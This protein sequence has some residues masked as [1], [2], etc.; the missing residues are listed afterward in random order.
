MNIVDILIIV[1]LVFGALVG[2]RRGFTKQLVSSIGLIVIVILA[3]VLKN[4]LSALLYENLP[5]FKFGGIFKGVT[6]LN[7][8]V[9]EVLAFFIVL[10]ILMFIF[11]ILLFVTSIFEKFL[12]MT[13]I[14]GIPSKILGAILGVLENFILVFILLYIL[15]LPIFNINGLN[16]SKLKSGILKKTPILSTQVDKSVKVI[17]EFIELKDKYESINDSNSF[18]LE[19]LDLLLKHKITTVKSVE[20]LIEKDKI[21]INNI[22]TVLQKY[23]EG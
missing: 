21:Q 14:L 3:F 7:I 1:F 23:R 10:S 18:N 5:F 17:D 4:P 13:I 6:A 16:D 11:K 20:K 2:F 19:A 12:T 9:Y 22:E 8:L 15:S